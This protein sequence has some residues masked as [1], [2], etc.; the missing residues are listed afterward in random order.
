MLEEHQ[1]AN[2]LPTNTVLTL[3]D[4]QHHPLTLAPHT[5]PGCLQMGG[6]RIVELEEENL[7]DTAKYTKPPATA[8]ASPHQHIPAG[9][10]QTA[11]A[12]N[13]LLAVLGHSTPSP[14]SHCQ[15]YLPAC[16]ST[17]DADVAMM[18]ADCAS[19]GIQKQ[20]HG[21]DSPPVCGSVDP[22]DICNSDMVTQ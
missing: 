2:S 3:P 5:D 11:D 16:S 14:G 17:S 7:L 10:R 4:N 19:M 22:M 15:G 9:P 21:L 12:G 6:P 13:G 8:A 18:T 1:Q 20:D